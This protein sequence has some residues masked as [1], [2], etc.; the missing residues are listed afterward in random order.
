MNHNC[1]EVNILIRADWHRNF[2]FS[3]T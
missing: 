1:N 2:Y 3:F